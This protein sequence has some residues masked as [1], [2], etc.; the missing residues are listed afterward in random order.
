MHSLNG[1]DCVKLS[2]GRGR[3]K[4][5]IPLSRNAE[6]YLIKTTLNSISTRMYYNVRDV[7]ALESL[8][9]RISWRNGPSIIPVENWFRV[10]MVK[11]KKKNSLLKD[12]HLSTRKFLKGLW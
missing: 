2:L 10:F 5:E 11:E 1:M 3:K 6:V 9:K 12:F 7:S 4:K 8:D